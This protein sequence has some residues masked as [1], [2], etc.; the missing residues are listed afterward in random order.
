MVE[1]IERALY[2]IQALADENNMKIAGGKACE[3][4]YIIYINVYGH[5]VNEEETEKIIRTMRV[6]LMMPMPK[7]GNIRIKYRVIEK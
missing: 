7:G 5:K 2:A 4:E 6:M 1:L 3:H